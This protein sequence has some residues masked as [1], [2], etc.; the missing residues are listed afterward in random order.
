MKDRDIYIESN[1]FY[2]LFLIRYEFFIN[3]FQKNSFENFNFFVERK[4]ESWYHY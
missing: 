3:N 4:K 2:A 1:I